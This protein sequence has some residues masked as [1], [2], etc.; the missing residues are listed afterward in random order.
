MFF[1]G[2]CLK[3]KVL[4]RKKQ[5]Q[6]F[7]FLLLLCLVA[8]LSF[9]PHT[10]AFTHPSLLHAHL[11]S[12]RDT[13][14]RERTERIDTQRPK[15]QQGQ[16]L[17]AIP[18]HLRNGDDGKDPS[19]KKI[20]PCRSHATPLQP[21]QTQ[22]SDRRVKEPTTVLHSHWNS[23]LPDN[24]KV[25]VFGGG[26][27]ALAMASLFAR[28]NIPVTMLLRDA[29]VAD[30]MNTERRHPKYMSDLQIP[31]GLS[32]TADPEEALRGVTHIFHCVPCQY[33]REFLKGV[34]EFVPPGTPIVS[35]SKGIEVGTL[36]LMKD[37]IKESIQGTYP[38][39]FISGP[40]FAREIVQCLPT[41]VV[42]ASEEKE[43][44][45]EVQKMMKCDYFQVLTTTDVM[46]VELGGAI[47]NVVAIAAG[48]SEGLELGMNAQA[49]LVTAG[50]MEMRRVGA[51]MGAQASTFAGLSGAGDAFAT[52]FGPLSRN[53]A[54]GNRL[55]RGET[56]EAILS[57]SREVAEGVQTSRSLR[58]LIEAKSSGFRK[59][60]KFPI[61]FGIAQILDGDM[62]PR[63][64]LELIMTTRALDAAYT[65]IK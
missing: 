60:L 45:R 18:Q 53:R 46:G 43:F 21:A 42:V 32:A 7:L 36:C 14:R 49:A 56:M 28:K 15:E 37:V 27:F 2:V 40:S 48:I 51:L 55:G 29:G 8:S 63:E 22:S 47:K 5:K 33:S 6:P 4:W 39:A 41:A 3:R 25:V 44:A 19:F 57:S 11:K 61:I 50:T 20:R 23:R 16:S 24:L 65:R 59:D 30:H 31:D 9:P 26:N 17:F 34:A 52:C 54:L 10:D 38:T 12:A 13:S 1:C 58:A 64:G 35:A 62:T